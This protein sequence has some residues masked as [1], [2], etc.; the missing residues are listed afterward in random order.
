M[1]IKY[2][3]GTKVAQVYWDDL[4]ASVKDNLFNKLGGNNGNYD[5]FPVAEIQLEEKEEILCRF[6][7]HSVT[8]SK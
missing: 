5:I 6:Q 1:K 8:P 3:N 7:Q 4:T 2:V